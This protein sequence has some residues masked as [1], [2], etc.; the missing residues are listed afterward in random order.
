MHY[1]T[2]SLLPMAFTSENAK[3]T[4]AELEERERTLL[5]TRPRIDAEIGQ[6]R[7]ACAALKA[8]EADEPASFDGKLSDAVRAVLKVNQATRSLAPTDVRD[9]VRA[10]GYDFSR[11]ENEMA[12]IHG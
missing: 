4:I 11:H 8:L 9:A 6:V 7:T 3:N 1:V 2:L 12:A 10:L 5:E